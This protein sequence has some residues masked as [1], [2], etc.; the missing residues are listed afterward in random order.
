MTSPELRNS[1]IASR[2]RARRSTILHRASATP[3]ME[4][5]QV[6]DPKKPTQYVR[7]LSKRERVDMV[8]YELNEKHRWSIKDLVYHL[9]TAEPIKKY[10]ITC[11]TRAKALSDAIYQQ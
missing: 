6:V 8:L 1:T 3:S 10:G 5:Q 9:V 2:R 7:G 11:S 4:K